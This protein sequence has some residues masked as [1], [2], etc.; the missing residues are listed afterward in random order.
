[1]KKGLIASKYKCP[2]CGLKMI[3]SPFLRL[4]DGWMWRCQR[5]IMGK[6][7]YIKR[8]VRK[9]SWF[10]NSSLSLV[11]LLSMTYMLIANYK[12][13]LIAH[14]LKITINTIPEWRKFYRLVCVNACLNESSNV[15]GENKIV[16]IGESA[17]DEQK[18]SKDSSVK[19]TWIFWG[20][21]H[22]SRNFFFEVVLEK[23]KMML[24]DVIKQRINPGSTI[25][26]DLWKEYNTSKDL[27]FQR[28][29]V[30]HSLVL[31]NSGMKGQ[32]S[33]VKDFW[34]T[35]QRSRRRMKEGLNQID[36]HL[37]EFL[38][39]RSKGNNPNKLFASFIKEVAHAC[40]PITKD[41]RS[42]KS[43]GGN[44]SSSSGESS[45]SSSDES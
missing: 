21:E 12:C 6:R 22:G 37:A 17:F 13:K 41:E 35:I 2:T 9:G 23:S 19:G 31:K 30:D 3:L 20:V 24:L 11:K 15:G 45:S 34:N 43:V 4:E 42:V 33:I 16:E 40:Q 39:R 26:S 14:E 25:I 38:W 28:L 10:E 36:S 1:M 27:Q 32:S 29:S 7:H 18:Y 5:N 44:D 8:S